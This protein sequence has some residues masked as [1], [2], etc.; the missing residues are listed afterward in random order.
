[1]K[2]N[3]QVFIIDWGPELNEI[4]DSLLFGQLIHVYKIPDSVYEFL[5]RD[6]AQRS[7]LAD[8]NF[9]CPPIDFLQETATLSSLLFSLPMQ[10]GYFCRR[11][12]YWNHVE[13][14]KRRCSIRA[15]G[16]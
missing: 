1:M 2:P 9:F 13:L 7:C 15:K 5:K 12:A 4:G 11:K 16:Y 10:L 14:R 3:G 6:L 8:N